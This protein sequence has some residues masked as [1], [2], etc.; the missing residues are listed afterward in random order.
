[1]KA[2]PT[3][4]YVTASRRTW[5]MIRAAYLSGLSAPTVAARFGVS[6]AGLRKRAQRE[7]WTKRAQ[8]DWRGG[9][10]VGPPSPWPEPAP[11]PAPAAPPPVPTPGPDDLPFDHANLHALAVPPASL[12]AGAVARKALSLAMTALTR[13]RSADA[14]R[15]ARAAGLIAKLDE[16]VPQQWEVDD[17]DEVQ[18]RHSALQDLAFNIAGELAEALMAGKGEILPVYL[19]RARQWRRNLG[20]PEDY[21]SPGGGGGGGGDAEGRA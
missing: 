12:D 7:G 1:M 11:A 18:S 13:G 8:A 17:A 21:V 14:L 16:V 19:E 5:E 10:Q 15:L 3:S 4:S 2:H 20:L 6:V 9:V